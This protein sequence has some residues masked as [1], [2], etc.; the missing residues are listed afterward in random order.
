MRPIRDTNAAQRML[1]ALS[2][3]QCSFLTAAGI[4]QR[5]TRSA[6]ASR[7]AHQIALCTH[8]PHN[9]HRRGLFRLTRRRTHVDATE[10]N[11]NTDRKSPICNSLAKHIVTVY[12][13][14]D[15]LDLVLF[16]GFPNSPRWAAAAR[17]LEIEL[18][19]PLRL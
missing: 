17:G 13:A 7:P 2:E 8:D 3:F 4:S 10:S 14:I 11:N 16:R 6:L 15:S 9:M 19:L 12:E 5:F 1:C 18:V